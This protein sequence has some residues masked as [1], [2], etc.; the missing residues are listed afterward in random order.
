MALFALRYGRVDRPARVLAASCHAEGSCAAGCATR[1]AALRAHRGRARCTAAKAAWLWS[2]LRPCLQPGNTSASSARCPP[3]AGQLSGAGSIRRPARRCSSTS[4]NG[5]SIAGRAVCTACTQ[6]LNASGSAIPG[7]ARA[8][9]TKIPAGPASAGTLPQRLRKRGRNSV[10]GTF[11]MLPAP[12]VRGG[13][14]APFVEQ[15]GPA[16][17]A[18][19]SEKGPG[20]RDSRCMVSASPVRGDG[21]GDGGDAS[22][23]ANGDHVGAGI[24]STGSVGCGSL[25]LRS[26]SPASDVSGAASDISNSEDSHQGDSGGAQGVGGE[27]G[28]GNS[29]AVGSTP[30]AWAA[31]IM[32]L[33]V[34]GRG[35][36]GGPPCEDSYPEAEVRPEAPSQPAKLALLL[37]AGSAAG[38]AHGSA[39]GSAHGSAAG[40]AAG[41]VAVSGAMRGGPADNCGGDG[42]RST[43]GRASGCVAAAV[44]LHAESPGH[45]MATHGP[46]VAPPG[47]VLR[48]FDATGFR[49]RAGCICLSADGGSVLVIS[50]STRVGAWILPAGGVDPGESPRT[51]A[52]RETVEEAGVTGHHAAFLCWVDDTA[53][54]TRTAVYCLAVATEL[55]EYMERARRSRR[56]VPLEEAAAALAG[57]P[58]AQRMLEAGLRV[59]QAAAAGAAAATGAAVAGGSGAQAGTGSAASLESGATGGSGNQHEGEGCGGA[60]AGLPPGR[61]GV[62]VN[63]LVA[64]ADEMPAGARGLLSPALSARLAN[65]AR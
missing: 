40:S 33:P 27:A 9:D 26:L 65:A 11:T 58:Y 35:Y 46:M 64:A 34:G 22:G 5:F 21:G 48:T 41:S 55:D 16:R 17:T 54:R 19:T 20:T 52:L 15:S 47:T 4:A 49:L 37:A 36:S 63:Y 38:S 61:T 53:K 23:D 28:G 29:A 44:S 1:S 31:F 6:W 43:G 14:G 2:Q 57:A 3:E 39:A 51:A 12:L 30:H 50:S 18:A 7:G 62:T 10:Q 32:S 59:L 13:N 56:W 42:V 8:V 25:P 60:T 24:A 45:A